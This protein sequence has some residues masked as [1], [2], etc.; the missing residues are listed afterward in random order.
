M[1]INPLFVYLTS[2]FSV[3]ILYGLNLTSNLV[4][5]S[6]IGMLMIAINMIFF[7]VVYYLLV[8]HR[9]KNIMTIRHEY[10]DKIQIYAKKVGVIWFL[11]TLFEIYFSGGFPLYWAMVGIPKL[12]TEFG[13]PSFHGIMNALYL[14][15]LTMLFYLYLCKLEHKNVYLVF[16]LLMFSWPVMMLGRGILV[17]AIIQM[18]CIYLMLNKI[19]LSHIIMMLVTCLTV[20]IV[21]GM[22]GDMRQTVNPFAY[23][24]RD[25]NSILHELPSGFLWFY[26]YLTAGLSNLFHN[27]D[28]IEPSYIPQFSFSNM[29]PTIVRNL[30]EIDPRNDAFI[31]VDANL[32]TS[33]AYAGFVSD[34]GAIGGVVFFALIH[35]ILCYIYKTALHGKPW[36]IFAYAVVVQIIAFS[37]FYDMF[38]L[39]PTL[40][41]FVVCIGLKVFTM[42]DRY[43]Y[44][45]ISMRDV[46]L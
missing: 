18:S 19:K 33:T 45:N 20:V 21:F 34:F 22:L 43:C 28:L 40:F 41:Q 36:S 24:I 6:F 27:V 31:F 2:W 1:I 25:N 5:W 38:L 16:I 39:L 44:K 13:V 29:L 14:Q 10:T 23:L 35:S 17:S 26:V 12:Y 4:Q 46:K 30:F 15:L 11:G 37:I 42:N 7:C 32:N 8:G 3:L 9:K